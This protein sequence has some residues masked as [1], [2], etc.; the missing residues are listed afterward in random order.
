M[1][2]TYALWPAPATIALKLPARTVSD[3]VRGAYA[4]LPLPVAVSDVCSS[5]G[6]RIAHRNRAV[7]FAALHIRSACSYIP[8]PAIWRVACEE[9]VFC[10][11]QTFI[12]PRHIPPGCIPLPSHGGIHSSSQSEGNCPVMADAG[13]HNLSSRTSAPSVILTVPDD[14]T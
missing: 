8:L 3:S 11:I 13:S 10:R 12:L 5:T 6:C 2:P 14:D 7:A 9:R 1:L 4:L